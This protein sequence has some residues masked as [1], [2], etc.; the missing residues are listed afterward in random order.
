MLLLD[1][2][3]PPGQL[4]CHPVEGIGKDVHLSD[5]GRGQFAIEALV[6]EGFGSEAYLF[7]GSANP[8]G[9]EKGGEQAEEKEGDAADQT[10]VAKSSGRRLVGDSE[11]GGVAEV[12]QVGLAPLSRR[13]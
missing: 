2:V 10:P 3:D 6:T 1:R 11:V 5:V 4:I 8:S 13:T 12:D 7:Q 9:D